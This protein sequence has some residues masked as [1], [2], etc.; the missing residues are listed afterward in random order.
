MI[1]SLLL[2]A[3]TGSGDDTGATEPALDCPTPILGYPDQDGDSFGAGDAVGPL[4]ERPDGYVANSDD[5][6]DTDADISPF[7][8]ELCD[9]IDNDCDGTTDPGTAIDALTCFVDA[10]GDGFGDPA[11]P[12]P[13]CACEDGLADNDDDCD[14]TS[15]AVNPSADEIVFDGVDQDCN[16]DGDE[17]DADGDGY[18][19]EG[20]GDGSDCDDGDPSVNPGAL[21]LCDDDIDQDCDGVLD[22]CL[23]TGELDADDDAWLK[24]HRSRGADR[25]IPVALFGQNLAHA[26]DSN[27]DGLPEIVALQVDIPQKHT[28][29]DPVPIHY[30]LIEI[31][32]GTSGGNRTL[33]ELTLATWP[34]PEPDTYWTGMHSLTDTT[35]VANHDFD[36]DG[37]TDFIFSTRPTQSE[38][39]R[40]RVDLSYGPA[41]GEQDLDAEPT[42]RYP[43]DTVE[44]AGYIEIMQPPGE[45]V[46]W[47]L[48][49][50]LRP[51]SWEDE[52]T[53]H[54]AVVL[55]SEQDFQDST[56]LTDAPT[57]WA[58]D[59]RESA[60]PMDSADLDGDGVRDLVAGL[61]LSASGPTLSGRVAVF[62]GPLEGVEGFSDAD[63]AIDGLVGELY[64][65]LSL[66]VVDDPA[67]DGQ[68]RLAIGIPESD[69][70]PEGMFGFYEVGDLTSPRLLSAEDRVATLVSDDTTTLSTFMKCADV[71][72]VDGDGRGEFAVAITADREYEWV[73]ILL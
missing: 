54:P 69:Q 70:R 64:F 38:T 17:Y 48:T 13:A 52:G 63:L 22:E 45:D 16:G 6:D 14:D 41:V 24:I 36:S 39:F 20:H 10:D 42:L 68:P 57:I 5:C 71:G 46:A 2:L 51:V 8:D 3:C 34:M 53:E 55:L 7:A 65:G 35:I 59:G 15:D 19:A 47:T 30:I 18:N 21:D 25:P 11:Q 49:A 56:D 23:M 72:D 1:P 66:C 61:S 32:T 73:K 12:T 44:F 40:G 29:P 50:N 58:D 33:D 37:Y 27:G 62:H 31:P 60:N 43:G 9:G 67:G 26:G 28:N 4:C